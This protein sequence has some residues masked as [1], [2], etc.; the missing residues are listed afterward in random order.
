MSYLELEETISDIIVKRVID[1]GL[2]ILNGF[3]ARFI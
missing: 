2:N 1:K 3:G